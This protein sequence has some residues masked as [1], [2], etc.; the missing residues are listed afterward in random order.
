MKKIVSIAL[1]LMMVLALATATF[2]AAAQDNGSPTPDDKP[3]PSG[4]T[5]GTSPK[6]G[7]PVAMAAIL[8]MAA[9]GLGVYAVKK[10]TE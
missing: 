5:D 3:T 6:T 2:S 7:Y 10:V 9:M 8:M 1:V 4:E